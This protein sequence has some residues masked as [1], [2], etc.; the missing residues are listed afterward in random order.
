[1]SAKR[2]ERPKRSLVRRIARW[3]GVSV[4]VV[5]ALA[6]LLLCF[7]QT[8]WGHELVRAR[9]EAKL[10]ARVNGTVKL[11]AVEYSWLFRDVELRD[12]TVADAAGRPALAIGSLRATIDRQSVFAKT[13]VIDELTI[14]GLDVTTA[15]LA[16]IAKPSTSGTP[17][18]SFK[19]EHL[20]VAGAITIEKSDGTK[21]SVR[22]LAVT[23][24]VHARPAAKE[25]ELALRDVSATAT[26]ARPGHAPREVLVA[27][28]SIV[29]TKR[30][31]A[32]DLEISSFSAGAV[33]VETLVAHVALSGVQ[34]AGT[35]AIKVGGLRVDNN[36]LS[37][38]LGREL[39][40]DDATVDASIIGPI[41]KLVV[42][43]D[44]HIG[45]SHLAL[46]GTVDLSN[47]AVPKY[48]L[49]VVGTALR[50]DV[51][52]LSNKRTPPI[53]TSL[54]GRVVGSGLTR[55]SI[56]AKLSLEVGATTVGELAVDSVV[57]EA[58]ASHGAFRIDRLHAIAPGLV[59]DGEGTLSA[60]RVLDGTVTMHATPP[61][62]V[63]TLARYDVVLPPHA[64]IPPTLDVV[65]KAHGPI[66]GTIAVA[67]QS[68][69]IS[70]SGGR[71]AI[72]GTASIEDRRL[73]AAKVDV[74]LH[75]LDLGALARLGGQRPKLAGSLS[76][77]LM[78]TKNRNDHN[79]RFE[80]AVA[81][82]TFGVGVSVRGRAHAKRLVAH[83]TATRM[84][85]R[86]VVATLAA[87]VPL[88][89]RAGVPAL[90]PAARMAV[91]LDVA[92]RS[93]AELDTLGVLGELLPVGLRTKLPETGDVELHVDLRGTPARPTGTIEVAASTVA[94]H[95]ETQR[96][97]LHGGVTS[98][99]GKVVVATRGSAWL[100]DEAAPIATIEGRITTVSPL[101]RGVL[102]LRTLWAATVD[103]TIV[104]PARQLAE[105]AWL[106]AP[107]E[108][109]GTLDGRVSVTGRLAAPRFA[110]A[111]TL[112]DLPTAD[113]ATH[114]VAIAA[115]GTTSVI[116][117]TVT[118]GQAL[119][120]VARMDRSTPG[121]MTIDG[122]AEAAK[123]PLRT[124]IPAFLAARLGSHSP[125]LLDWDMTGK[126]VL[127]DGP[128]GLSIDQLAVAGTLDL[129][130][131]EILVPNSTRRWRDIQLS[132]AS[133]P[134]GLRIKTLELHERDREVADRLIRA[135]GFVG[136]HRFKP[137]HIKLA[138]T[139]RDWLVSGT[140][141]LGKHDAPR[142]ALDA[143]LAIDVDLRGPVIAVDATVNALA[144]KMPDPFYRAH[145]YENAA[146]GGDIIYTDGGV[147][148]GKLP[149]VAP[150]AASAPRNWRPI[151][152]RVHIPRSIRVQ[153]PPLEVEAKGDLAISVRDEGITARGTLT[154]IDGHA[155]V[156]G[157]RY[158]L[159]QGSLVF[160]DEHPTGWL[161]LTLDHPVS[162]PVARNLS[163]PSAGAARV[164]LRGSVAHP[165]RIMGGANNA[166]LLEAM[167]INVVGRTS[168]NSAPDL[169]ASETVNLTRL[170]P[171]LVQTFMSQNL[172]HLLF[173]DRI[174]AYADP[175]RDRATYGRIQN[176]EAERYA[177]D[178]RS[179]A[180]AVARPPTPGRSNAELQYD[181]LFINDEH[182]A[183]G[184]GLRAGDR[185]GGGVGV[186]VEWNS[187]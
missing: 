8:R 47:I 112:H 41:D 20:R 90:D 3:F 176:V 122:R 92:K 89:R 157:H 128:S 61:A 159:T 133:E 185:A 4:L 34:L 62:L 161:D 44:V 7:L 108:L 50:S 84:Q 168:E 37:A 29:A 173:L 124:L 160:T 163:L 103:G 170:D 96:L 95:G 38:L 111:F 43:G 149:Y 148:A 70:I 98:S 19:I 102:E 53:A 97:T 178:G 179:R 177:K 104:L 30:A 135:T 125:G 18:G 114:D 162:A 28:A 46:D 100:R 21:V 93:L 52:V 183:V 142:A 121:R 82:P 15:R 150:R 86:S 180:R 66:D 126:L 12:V 109:G 73:A 184:V 25:L 127:V 75:E 36:Q 13:L 87:D 65:V 1:M 48:D 156:M 116:T 91:K 141:S 64:P 63:A 152:V 153:Q 80:L 134:T 56:D 68:S 54:R 10:D 55:G 99:A 58:S 39:L 169:P 181:R 154:V 31:N 123:A 146:L 57:L 85:D 22:D 35:Q 42:D 147:G 23:G 136:W 24:S 120:L 113:G 107:R 16:G 60:D 67:V 106:G 49:V 45:P 105:L 76:G 5:I 137:Q 164:S 78:L 129:R 33:S 131:G 71:I 101:A 2:S 145:H 182:T 132:V 77:S 115:E 175:Y 118:H 69:D 174:T 14:A 187:D 117:A 130:G 167:S 166:S 74:G 79:A 119:K 110:A 140:K 27:I 94:I 143:D 32:A 155:E 171:L 11:G 9:I 83:L 40:R 51:I 158:E 151:D 139:T 6:G 26:F 165:A 81:L 72:K 144:F 17:M 138:L 186:F 88:T 59:F 172:P